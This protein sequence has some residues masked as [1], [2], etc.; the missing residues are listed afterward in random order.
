MPDPIVIL[1]IGLGSL[2][3][4][5]VAA[6]GV[7]VRNSI[8]RR[9]LDKQLGRGR[10]NFVDGEH[11]TVIGKVRSTGKSLTAPFSGHA[12]VAYQARV[13]LTSP[14]HGVMSLLLDESP[15]I[16]HGEVIP[17][18]LDTAHGIVLVDATQAVLRFDTRP[19]IP[20]RVERESAFLRKLGIATTMRDVTCQE[21]Y[22]SLDQRVAVHGVLSLEVAPAE[23]AGYRDSVV[24][25]H[26][27]ADKD[28]A[29]TI[30]A[31]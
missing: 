18:A 7:A 16:E 30:G 31:A 26:L 24:R 2:G 4:S 22:V 20:R 6:A 11:T 15:N 28:H 25:A 17:F 9:R 1:L 27:R 23:T 8:R 29:V 5:G 10:D 14:K 21:V 3:V 13:A 12:C 19:V